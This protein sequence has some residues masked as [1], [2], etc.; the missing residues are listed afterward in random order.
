MKKYRLTST[1][2]AL[3]VVLTFTTNIFA[4]GA[5][6]WHL[7]DDATM[8]I[9][10]GRINE[11]AYSPDGTKMAVGT[12]IGIWLY[13]TE[14]AKELN[15][16]TAHTGRVTSVTFSPDG[17]TLASGSSDKTIRLWDVENGVTL[18]TLKGHRKTVTSVAFSPDG[19]TLASGSS[20]RTIRLWNVATGTE[21]HTLTGHTRSI[22][23]VVFNHDSTMLAS[24]SVFDLIRLWDVANGTELRT[25][26][27]GSNG[28]YSVAF[29]PVT[30]TLASG[31]HDNRV[32]LWNADTGTELHTLEKHTRHVSHV[33]FSPDGDILASATYSYWDRTIRLWHTDTGAEL[34]TLTG[35]TDGFSDITFNPGGDILTSAGVDNIIRLWDVNSGTELRT[36][37][38]HT[39]DGNTLL[40][41]ERKVHASV[42]ADYSIRLW[43]VETGADLPTLIGHTDRIN[44]IAFNPDNTM[45]VTSS[46]DSTVRVWDVGTGMQLHTLLDRVLQGVDNIRF[47]PDGKK[48]AVLYTFMNS[49]V[50]LF[51]AETGIE[52][53]SFKVFTLPPLSSIP[54][55]YPANEH[56]SSPNYIMFSPDGNSI[57][58]ISIIYDKTIRIWDAA[59]GKF[60]NVLEAHTGSINSVRFS[61]D[62]T[63]LATVGADNTIR[64]WDVQTWMEMQTLN[65]DSDLEVHPSLINN[66]RFSPDGT[67]LATV[68]ADNTIRIWDV[69]TWMEMQTLNTDSDSVRSIAFSADGSLFATGNADGTIRLWDIANGQAVRTF[70]GHLSSVSMI[71]F[72]LDVQTLASRSDDGTILVWD[73][74]PVEPINTV[75]S[76][77]PASMQSP[78]IGEN[79]V[80]TLNI[81]EAENVAAYQATVSY[82]NT[83]LRYVESVNGD[84]LPPAAYVLKPVV[85]TD[86]VTFAATSFAKERSGEGTLATITFEVVAIKASTLRLSDVLLSNSLGESTKP[87]IADAVITQPQQRAEDVNADGVVDIT[88]LTIVASN[89]GKTGA[90][91]ADVNDDGV[92]N[93]V[94]LALV[95][96]AIGNDDG[97]AVPFLLS[98]NTV[99]MPARATVEAW[100]QEARKVNLSDPAFQRGILMLESLLKWLTPKTTALLANY[101]NPFNPETWIPYQLAKSADVNISI[102]TTDGKLIR[103]LDLGHQ[104]IGMYHQRSSAAYWDGKNGLGESVASGVYFY[105]FSAGEFSATR[106]L[107]I[108]K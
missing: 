32:R 47:S 66:V 103:Q 98:D 11:I 55:T 50:F 102:Y 77:S 2:I 44:N 56:E 39:V 104:P 106:K 62:G 5:L 80:F 88:D 28:A 64:I 83:A 69:Q 27:A 86:K 96:A 4:Q 40:Y 91:P 59:T 1:L 82:D 100:L 19:A 105:T 53:H 30:N 23:E 41:P 15:L 18:H 22:N 92:V 108:R 37:V 73:I 76:L 9:G 94:D 26:R 60:Q 36:F 107:L 52:L 35:H 46:W 75:V 72:S 8:R 24:A 95:A 12:N 16:F 17:A 33:T 7:P 54:P 42:N 65:T 81:A 67:K 87:N 49:W 51:D 71:A 89:F 14:T 31:G 68:G 70:K 90:N 48:I 20:D 99:N 21:R 63:T 85:D 78:A 45:V 57:L 93:I 25:L 43:D 61:P 58:T 79:L 3:F 84:F 97:T 34:H 38:D 13:E 101:P 74:T 10:I 29:S 6:Q